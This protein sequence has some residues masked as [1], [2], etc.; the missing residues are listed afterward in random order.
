[1]SK[2]TPVKKS[3]RRLKRSVRR[4]LAAVLMVTAIAVAAIPVPEN[5]AE[6]S[7]REAAGNARAYTVD[8]SYPEK[9][10]DAE[11]NTSGVN[12]A[13]MTLSSKTHTKLK[14][15]DVLSYSYYISQIEESWQISWQFQYV[16][17]TV[18]KIGGGMIFEYNNLNNQEQVTLNENLI[19]KYAVIRQDTYN[20][21]LDSNAGNRIVCTSPDG[22]EA[23][24]FKEYY[25]SNYSIF[26]NQYNQYIKD[27]P[28]YVQSNG[29]A[30]E[31]SMKLSDMSPDA[32]MRYYCDT[33]K[34]GNVNLKG[35]TL[36]E[37][38]NALPTDDTEF[39]KDPSGTRYYIPCKTEAYNGSYTLFDKNGFMY[40]SDYPVVG[41]GDGVFKGVKN[42]NE[43][44][45][46][47]H[48]KF[49][50]DN[51]FEGSF[52][53]KVSFNNVDEIGNQAFKDCTRLQTIE[54]G[55]TTTMIGTEAFK[56]DTILGE[57]KFT[58]GVREVG[59]GAFAYC[60]ALKTVDFSEVTTQDVRVG[61]YAFYNDFSLGKVNFQSTATGT[62][63]DITTLGEG[64]FAIDSSATITGAGLT[65]FVFPNRISQTKGTA[66]DT[67]P[68]EN[69]G[70]GL[71][72]LVLAGRTNIENV[73][74]P[75][76][77]GTSKTMT[78][79]DDLF[80]NCVS[81][82]QVEFPDNGTGS[83]GYATYDP[84][85]LFATV[86]NTSFIVKGPRYDRPNSGTPAGPRTSTWKAKTAIDQMKVP[87]LY[88]V[89]GVEYY[90]VSD[91]NY[92]L[93]IDSKGVLTS[94][95]LR[96]D[97]TNDE[98]ATIRKNGVHLEIPAMVG[99][100]KVTGIASNC[101][102]DN[103]LNQA[104][105]SLTIADGSISEINNEVFKGWNNLE[106]VY[107]GDSV[108]SI[109]TRAFANCSKLIDVTFNTPANGDY[110]GFAI[111]EEAFKTGSGQLT[112][113]G[114]IVEGY[115]PFEWAT[116]PNNVIRD[117]NQIRVCYK[118][119][120]PEFLTVM[121]NPITEK[122][123]LLD[124]PKYSQI[125]DLLEEAHAW[126]LAQTDENGKKLYSSY[127]D[128][129]EKDWYARYSG[130]DYD[131]ER[132][133]F[134]Y[135]WNKRV[136]D[137][138]EQ[139]SAIYSDKTLYGPWVNPDFCESSGDDDN[140]YWQEWINGKP[141]ASNNSIL[142]Q[143]YDMLFEPLVVY[144]ADDPNGYYKTYPYNVIENEASGDQ[145]RLPTSEER[146]I[147]YATQNIV[148]PAGV[149]SIDV[150]GYVNDLTVDREENNTH[151]TNVWNY[152]T[153]FT[154]D[155]DRDGWDA[156]TIRMYLSSRKDA[157]DKTDE[158]DIVPGLFSGY[159]KDYEGNDSREVY[160]RG[161]DWLRTV[162]L[163]SVE[164]LPPYAFD[165]CEQLELVNLGPNCSDIGSA[166]FRG[167][168]RLQIVGDND[169]YKT[170]NGIIYS[171]DTDGAYTIEECLSARGNLVGQSYISPLEDPNLL[172][173]KAIRAGAFEDCGRITSVD[174][175][176]TAGLLNIPDRA[177]RHCEQLT[178]V[179]LPESVNSIQSEA[180]A[181]DIPITVTI[182]GKE[183]FIA[184][185]A[186]EHNDKR[187]AVRT[188]PDTSALE[189]ANYYGLGIATPMLGEKCHVL[190]LDFDGTVLK[191]DYIE[192][193][194][195]AEVP[196]PEFPERDKWIYTG[197][198]S[199]KGVDVNKDKITEDTTFIAQG[200][201]TD[202]MVDGKYKVEF[203]DTI[204]FKVINTQYVEVGGTAVEPRVPEHAGYSFVGWSDTFTNI[205]SNKTIF[206]VFNV[207][208]S[209][210]NPNISGGTTNNPSGGTTS[211]PSGGTTNI[212]GN[213]TTT[214]N[215][216]TSTSSGTTSSSTSSSST[217][218]TST[219]EQSAGMYS[220]TVI[221]GSGSGTYPAGSTVLIM[222]NEPAAGKQFSKW[223]LNSQGV[224]LANVSTS[225]TTFV[226][227]STNVVVT[228]EFIDK[229][230]APPTGTVSTRP[231]GNTSGDSSNNNNGSTRVDITKPG[232]NNKDLATANVN[233]STDNFIVKISE[234]PEATQAV[235]NALTNKYGS[236]DSLLYYAMDISLYD[237][238][239]TT[240]ITDTTGLTVDITI[241][242]PDALITYG[243][244][245][246]MGA[247]VGDQME[248]LS[249]RFTTINGVPC[250]SFTATHFSP[251]TIYV[252][253]Q[254][255]SEG[256]LDT[257]PKTGDPIHPKWFLSLGLAC[258]SIILFMKKDRKAVVRKTA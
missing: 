109:G 187:V 198:R 40:V 193:G 87:Y 88:I 120:S 133:A 106:M 44:V 162:D 9:V 207:T 51:A 46:P 158:L 33:S 130:E 194:T 148:V 61:D 102:T 100:T 98:L 182:P 216:T 223:V 81:L 172:N 112:F 138:D 190:F 96:E 257:T 76:S 159:Y 118:S 137:G 143:F 174:L 169:Y 19:T 165:S 15:G 42:I 65:E 229:A 185:D 64:A 144:A 213:T 110:A 245:N 254:N 233:G 108:V 153:Y 113:H 92:L 105:K 255:L 167:C 68:Y 139:P 178:S 53:S 55:N 48:L 62:T 203:F 249:E 26:E 237:S 91:G 141:V 95:T 7:T 32:Q 5:Y 247:V 145:F 201:S 220:V 242:L 136:V 200:Y 250:I 70:T 228:A 160:K 202:T 90:E 243:G 206:T 23:A 236:L 186:F 177:F 128:M 30:P 222:A 251:Y 8:Y 209:S 212:S 58:Y 84:E 164:Y 173:V 6:D 168:T 227:P 230:A 129:M 246:M 4:S 22:V 49:I 3:K 241:P 74:M 21:W 151:Y 134:A 38:Q 225:L 189:Y 219:T 119:L 85:K 116:D 135:A 115:K 47:E 149:D 75:A 210:G 156:E 80:Y 199:A 161:N 83:C 93:C 79:P 253:T 86:G 56:G 150:Y 20:T 146:E 117:D 157:D 27:M 197:W 121:Y 28:G 154:S 114:D 39:G 221:N 181:D 244:N 234:T 122:V 217:S 240:K 103:T 179:V 11:G 2:K 111:G 147:I 37:V 195:Y 101:F 36:V 226:M 215:R 29:K 131:D 82:K 126:E 224:T 171:V 180:F 24:I 175:S 13:L 176:Q 18:N 73:T 218:A 238:T 97:L 232:I 123:T 60:S 77:Y 71:G 235:M 132:A 14:D 54:M 205:T 125:N 239:G 94:C 89:N 63:V 72:N 104:V 184:T 192:S 231:A 59:P 25:P 78:V 163:G 41:I 66:K 140:Y 10:T 208:G 1:M 188:Y 142:N 52:I 258:L 256:L 17:R 16:S 191:E 45:M 67:D 12:L 35:C 124:Y 170:E 214:S 31:L 248:D 196:K 34:Y 107:I 155:F 252:N 69:W 152:K 183:V 166:P 211:N 43:L 127:S 204:D 57:V 99:L 50:G